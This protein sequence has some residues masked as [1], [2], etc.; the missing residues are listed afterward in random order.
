MRIALIVGMTVVTA[1]A[2]AGDKI[3]KRTARL[4]SAAEA[5][6][7]SDVFISGRGGYHTYRIPAVILTPKG[8]L[9]AF[10]EGRKTSRSDH[11]DLDLLLRRSTDGGKTW[12]GM[13]VVYEAEV[14]FFPP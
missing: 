3:V 14:C 6:V 11:G 2:S 10:C 8:T 13:Q 4:S 5:P 12:G 1:S 7:R 9:L